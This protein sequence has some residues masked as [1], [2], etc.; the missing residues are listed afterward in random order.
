MREKNSTAKRTTRN[1]KRAT[2]SAAKKKSAAAVARSTQTRRKRATRPSATLP[3]VAERV[4]T[5]ASR[6]LDTIL[7]ALPEREL[8]GLIKRMR[9]RVEPKKRIDIPAQVARAL[10][11]QPDVREPERL[12]AASAELLRRIAELNGSLVVATLPAGVED[13]VRRGVV[14]A[15]LTEAGIELLL[16]TALLTQMRT[17]EGEDPRCLRALLS[18]APFETASAIASHYLQR[19]STPPIALSLE[20]AWEVLGDPDKLAAEL[21]ATSHLERRLLDGVDRVGGEVDAQ[22]LM[23]LEREPMRLRG[24]HGVSSGRRGAAFSL[25]KRGFLF[26]LY[27][28]R[29]VIPTE[30]ANAIGGERRQAREKRRDAI[31][32]HVVA[33][34]H[35]PRRARFST[36]P[37]ALVLA[38][39]MWLDTRGSNVTIKPGLG[40]PRSLVGRLAQHFGVSHDA[41]ALLVALSRAVGLWEP[42]VT[43]ATPPGSLEVWQLDELLFRT[44]KRGGAW[45]EGR[46]ESETLR[47]AADQ[48]DPSPAGKLRQMVLDALQDLGEGQWVP[49]GELASYLKND[50]RAGSL[51]RLFRRWSERVGVDTQAVDEVTARMLLVSLPILGVVDVGGEERDGDTS[52]MALRLT[53]RGRRLLAGENASAAP[54]PSEMPSERCIRVGGQV[55]V[56]RVVAVAPFVEVTAHAAELELKVSS[57]A[58]SRGLSLGID[59]ALMRKR[60]ER[61][62]VLSDELAD[63]LEHASTIVG[64]GSLVGCGGFLWVEDAAVR[65]MLARTA[66]AA[67]MFIDPSPPG[68]L[69]VVAGVDEER[70]LRNCRAIGVEVTVSPQARARRA[71]SPAKKRAG[72]RTQR[73]RRTRSWTAPATTTPRSGTPR[74]RK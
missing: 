53:T 62:A 17:W 47:L 56:A 65:D 22:E 59:A 34:D 58:M 74:S 2:K 38:M 39:R 33:E 6:R 3:I 32:Q 50:P 13:L 55:R 73:R 10:V 18:E 70:L 49:Y 20:P 60:L 42:Q 23:D 63:A 1:R 31:R 11:R 28:N 72:S 8:S 57:S 61:L 29:F 54:G 44:W 36:S 71:S 5:S 4:P 14:Y 51:T 45:D 52:H 66:P 21:A 69:L 9:I 67:D 68:G 41:T 7:R 37:T 30:V 43:V 46:A 48:R 19:P 12:P 27:P 40:T 16:P 25:E 35:L 26:P 15:L 24:V 64:R